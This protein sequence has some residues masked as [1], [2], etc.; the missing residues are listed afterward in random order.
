MRTLAG[1]ALAAKRTWPQRQ[2]PV[3]V[4]LVMAAVKRAP[5]RPRSR[6]ASESQ[7]VA[8]DALFHGRPGG[9]DL[10]E[11][12]E[13]LRGEV[14]VQGFHIIQARGVHRVAAKCKCHP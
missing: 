2:P 3:K 10:V 12:V 4:V 14:E 1:S 11:R 9:I 13:L 7:D 8:V 5:R 6:P